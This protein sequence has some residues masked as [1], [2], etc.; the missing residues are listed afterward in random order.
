MFVPTS[1]AMDE[2]GQAIASDFPRMVDHV[3]LV[4]VMRLGIERWISVR[5]SSGSE[6]V[7][8]LFS[9]PTRRRLQGHR[10]D[11]ERLRCEFGMGFHVPFVQVTHVGNLQV[12][13]CLQVNLLG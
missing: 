5:R 4:V 8:H 13:S 7:V 11:A 10:N 2:E 3:S 1:L 12:H 9:S 6:T